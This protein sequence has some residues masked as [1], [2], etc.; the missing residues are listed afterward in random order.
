MSTLNNSG[1]TSKRGRPSKDPVSRFRTLLWYWAVRSKSDLKDGKLDLLFSDPDHEGE[2]KIYA[3]RIRVFETIR[4]TGATISEGKHKR[5]GFNLIE[6]V[7]SHPNLVGS[8]EVYQS[9]LWEILRDTKPTLKQ[10]EIYLLD[11]IKVCNLSKA[12]LSIS[13]LPSDEELLKLSKLFDLTPSEINDTFHQEIN[14]KD[15]KLYDD[16]LGSFSNVTHFYTL[17]EKVEFKDLSC[18]LNILAF[19]ITFYR[20][21]MLTGNFHALVSAADSINATLFLLLHDIKW[22]NKDFSN[23]LLNLIYDCVFQFGNTIRSKEFDTSSF[24]DE[25]KLDKEESAL[26]NLLELLNKLPN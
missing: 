22:L 18:Y 10:T 17:L 8:A 4:M 21:A 12:K 14:T 11:L 6:R 15:R 7:N 20:Y 5:R 26:Y 25:I 1:N 23:D 2:H 3:E 9:K 24:I 19:Y 13:R 16:I